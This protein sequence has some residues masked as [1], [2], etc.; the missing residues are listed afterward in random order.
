MGYAELN[1]SKIKHRAY[2]K[3]RTHLNKRKK[4]YLAKYW[5]LKNNRIKKTKSTIDAL[6]IW[7][8]HNLWGASKLDRKAVAH[9]QRRPRSP[10]SSSNFQEERWWEIPWATLETALP[11]TKISYDTQ[12]RLIWQFPFNRHF[13]FFFLRV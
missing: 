5:Q 4:L 12:D 7:G 13:F 6:A 10:K 3:L 8:L 9:L 1:M 11:S 2:L